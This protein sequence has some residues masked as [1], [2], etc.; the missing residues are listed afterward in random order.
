MMRKKK[1]DPFFEKQ[2]KMLLLLHVNLQL[3]VMV[4]LPVKEIFNIHTL[5]K[6]F[7]KVAMNEVIWKHLLHRDIRYFSLPVAYDI[8]II[9][10][11][12]FRDTYKAIKTNISKKELYEIGKQF[13]DI[14]PP[15]HDSISQAVPYYIQSIL[16]GGLEYLSVLIDMIVFLNYTHEKI[17]CYL[18]LVINYMEANIF[19]A[20]NIFKWNYYII[21]RSFEEIQD[22]EQALLYYI[23]GMK[24]KN[25]DSIQ[26][27]INGIHCCQ[28]DT[29]KLI[30]FC[31]IA[32]TIFPTRRYCIL[33]AL[34]DRGTNPKKILELALESLFE[35]D[36]FIEKK[37]TDQ[38][39]FKP[40]DT[41]K[42]YH[43]V[44]KIAISY[45]QIKNYV[46]SFHYW[47]QVIDE[48]EL[49]PKIYVQ[50][51]SSDEKKTC[52]LDVEVYNCYVDAILIELDYLSKTEKAQIYLSRLV[53]TYQLSQEQSK[54][55][56]NFQVKCM[57]KY[58]LNYE[59]SKIILH[60][61]A[62]LQLCQDEQTRVHAYGYQCVAHYHQGNY[63]L[64][65]QF[66]LKGL[67]DNCFLR[68]IRYLGKCYLECKQFLKALEY[69]T[70]YVKKE[71]NCSILLDLAL[72]YLVPESDFYNLELAKNLFNEALEKQNANSASFDEKQ[73][74]ES[75]KL[76]FNK[77]F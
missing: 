46:E 54:K 2:K 24:Q 12:G 44:K 51:R 70:N 19:N 43:I 1:L 72:F 40:S 60:H 10:Q 47:K 53:A 16:K 77:I 20:V 68:T 55:L 66:G 14:S 8:A 3:H 62:F 64:G 15:T 26:A 69:F 39:V 11:F 42:R 52:N 38:W 57:D 36:Q 63:N 23:L 74:I 21:G 31:E 28:N 71:R 48:I 61:S 13:F 18:K 27:L 34:A 6:H 25:R 75:L 4:F 45:Y 49:E 76:K 58:L 5:S 73:I 65:I 9:E 7:H 30:G 17:E 56:V 32:L 50:T 59:W 37:I 35:Y 29:Q 33:F 67:H 41:M 22:Y